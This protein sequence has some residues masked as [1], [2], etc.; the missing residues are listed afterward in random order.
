M[1]GLKQ[2]H[3]GHDMNKIED[4]DIMFEENSSFF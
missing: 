1:S 2:A 4:N 3:G